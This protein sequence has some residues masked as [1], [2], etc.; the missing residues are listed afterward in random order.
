MGRLILFIISLFVSSI[1]SSVNADVKSDG[2]KFVSESAEK[3][4]SFTKK[5][6]SKLFGKKEKA[7]S[8]FMQDSIKQNKDTKSK[9][10]KPKKK[11]KGENDWRIKEYVQN[12]KHVVTY[13]YV[14]LSSIPRVPVI[15]FRFALDEDSCKTLSLIVTFKG[16]DNL[17]LKKGSKM[18]IRTGNG[19][20]YEGVT[21]QDVTSTTSL[22]HHYAT[23]GSVKSYYTS[24]EHSNI[25]GI[26]CFMDPD[27]IESIYNTG[28][29]KMRIAFNNSITD[30][31]FSKSI[32]LN[33]KELREVFD[34]INQKLLYPS[35]EIK[36][37]LERV[38]SSEYKKSMEIPEF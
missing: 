10:K 5:M 8:V 21:E 20:V 6:T 13:G 22:K 38:R 32:E 26:Y 37:E 15:D 3:V 11:K 31:D 33:N 2:K 28:V 19:N 27:I 23:A 29:L 16:D 34:A 35:D 7:D 18:L 9:R 36:A 14:H 4:S 12:G 30:Y 25:D 24:L 17:T 1:L